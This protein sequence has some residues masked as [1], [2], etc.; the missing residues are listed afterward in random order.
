[1]VR[2]ICLD[3]DVIIAFL[4]KDEKAREAI[5]L[6]DANFYTTA[7]NSF[8]VWFGRKHSENIFELFSW[9]TPMPLTDKIA[10]A[11]A[12]IQRDLE[13]KGNLV[14][15]RDLFIA[16]ICIENDLELFTYNLKDFERL[17]KYGLILIR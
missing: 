6:L 2:Q 8:E 4:N 3:S 14:A 13:R 16:A 11:A 17:E 15:I 12:D 1:M 7:I 10:R 5:N 9:L